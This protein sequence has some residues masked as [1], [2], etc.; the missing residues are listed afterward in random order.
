MRILII[1]IGR[2]KNGLS[3]ITKTDS[4]VT[5]VSLDDNMDLFRTHLNILINNIVLD[6]HIAN[7]VEKLKVERLIHDYR[8]YILDKNEDADLCVTKYKLLGIPLI[9][10]EQFIS[11]FV[12]RYGLDYEFNES[13]YNAL[14]KMIISP[15]ER[16]DMYLFNKFKINF[17]TD[18]YKKINHKTYERI[19]ES[20]KTVDDFDKFWLACDSG[21]KNIK[22]IYDISIDFYKVLNPRFIP[23]ILTLSDSGVGCYG[24]DKKGLV[25]SRY[26]AWMCI[27]GEHSISVRESIRT[28]SDLISYI[29][30]FSSNFICRINGDNVTWL[31]K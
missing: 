8:Q 16:Y 4:R 28:E 1:G 26:K 19:R 30:M 13:A 27:A 22:E 29:T 3:I 18:E 25:A 20:V 15:Y 24:C 12:L 7:D 11:F 21:F 9:N 17:Q 5:G 10:I 31:D 23:T 2:S 6:L 14:F